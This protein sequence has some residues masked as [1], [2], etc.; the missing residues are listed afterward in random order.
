MSTL[1]I[2]KINK[3]NYSEIEEIGEH[4]EIIS[5]N[6]DSLDDSRADDICVISCLG[7]EL[8]VGGE[9]GGVERNLTK[10]NKVWL[11]PR[12]VTIGDD[13]TEVLIS[14]L[15]VVIDQVLG[16]FKGKSLVRRQ[17]I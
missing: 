9:G 4:G 10:C 14:K 2:I 5:T 7:N 15:E 17:D 3:K 12:L 8:I 16:V 6:K 13:G 11:V 1:T